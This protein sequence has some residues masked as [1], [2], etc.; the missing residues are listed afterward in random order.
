MGMHLDIIIWFARKV[1]I[2]TLIYIFVVQLLV[3][4]STFSVRGSALLG[5]EKL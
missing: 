4:D 2:V 5:Q 1:V 3:L